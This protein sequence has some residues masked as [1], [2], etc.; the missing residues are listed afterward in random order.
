MENIK[1]KKAEIINLT[2]KINEC[3]EPLVDLSGHG[4]VLDPVYFNKNGWGEKEMY[5]RSG[6]VKKLEEIQR[7]LPDGYKF[8]IFDAYRSI[9]TQKKIYDAYKNELRAKRPELNEEQLEKS[10]QEFVVFP[11]LTK[12][13]PPRHN[14]G[15]AVDLTIVN[16][17]GEE[18]DMGTFFD[19]FGP[20][21]SLEYFFD[22]NNFQ[23]INL[24]KI[25]EI[26]NNRHL[27]ERIMSRAGFSVY[28]YEWWHWE[29]GTR[30]NA[31]LL[32]Q[33]Y[34]IYGSADLLN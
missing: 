5:L 17:K 10:T 2:V 18:L 28:P 31:A 19:H 33:E 4:F 6:V 23:G 34:A 21:A 25:E 27:L 29:R 32:G 8:K 11:K 7:S 22:E 26:R 9:K 12:E 3:G 20:E 13:A 1:Q 24:K 30:F 16:E 14:T 15:G